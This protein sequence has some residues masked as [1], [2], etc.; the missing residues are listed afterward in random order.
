MKFTPFLPPKT[1]EKIDLVMRKLALI[2]A[3]FTVNIGFSQ[4]VIQSKFGKGLY[5]VISADSSWS[6]KFG[7]RFQSLY[8]GENEIHETDGIGAGSSQFLIRRARLK[9]DGF[10]YSPKLKYKVE[11]GLSNR[12]LGRVGTDNNSAPNMILDAVLNWNFYQNFE[13]WAGQTKLPGN[14]ERVISSANMQFVDRSLLNNV[15][16]IDRDMGMQLRHYFTIGKSFR[17]QEMFA[18]S[19]G[20][21]RNVVQKNLG[22]LQYTSRVE[23]LPFGKF[24]GKGDYV[25][26]AIVREEKPKLAIGFTYDFNDRA[27]KTRSNQGSYMR[28]FSGDNED[29]FFHSDITTVFADMMFKYKGLS[30]M[31]EFAFRD[32]DIVTHTSSDPASNAVVSTGTGLNMCAGW[33]F[34]NNWEV[35]GRYTQI[36]PTDGDSEMQYTL[37]LSRYIVGHALKVQADVSYLTE[38][39][40]P[41]SELMYRL[42]I[43]IHF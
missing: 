16:N 41:T 27:V 30:I 2:L 31:G 28:D 15:F 36:N 19:Q 10:A 8:I 39:N 11:L 20:E 14:R 7:M 33:L 38:Q 17:V 21:G 6:M 25:G 43:D 24:G 32:A 1:I 37:G 18:V 22:G 4:E 35:A 23:V 26:G 3:L 13:L 12:D 9:F 40:N 42:Q 34:E 29:G 5:N